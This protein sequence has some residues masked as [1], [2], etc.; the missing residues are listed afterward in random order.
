MPTFD[1]EGVHMMD[2]SIVWLTPEKEGAIRS[3]LSRL[4]RD[5]DDYSMLCEALMGVA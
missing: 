3:N 1:G 5:E 2:A 4:A